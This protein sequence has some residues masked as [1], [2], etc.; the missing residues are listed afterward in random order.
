MNR[1]SSSIDMI[2]HAIA[3]EVR[4]L[5]GSEQDVE[6]ISTMA[7]CAIWCWGFAEAQG[8]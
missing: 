6:Q 1:W 5:G 8:N 7:A 2:R 4:S 3:D